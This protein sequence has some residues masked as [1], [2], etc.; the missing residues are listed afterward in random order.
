MKNKSILRE[1]IA[2]YVA[3]QFINASKDEIRNLYDSFLLEVEVGMLR[4]TMLYAHGNQSKATTI[5]TMSRATLRKKLEI[6]NLLYHGT[7]NQRVRD[8][9]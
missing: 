9:K 8:L 1:E 4:A 5:L 3:N 7:R 6:Y 2:D